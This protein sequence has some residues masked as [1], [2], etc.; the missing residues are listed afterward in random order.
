MPKVKKESRYKD[1]A[2]PK[3][4]MI[5]E[6][7]AIKISNKYAPEYVPGMIKG[8]IKNN[9][10]VMEYIPDAELLY[11]YIQKKKLSSKTLKQM[12]DFLIKIHNNTLKDKDVEKK[13]THPSYWNLKFKVQY[14]ELTNTK[15]Q[16]RKK[17]REF[18]DIMK[19]R[20]FTL[21]H[22]D[23]HFRNALIKKDKTIGVVD[24]EETNFLDS[25]HDV[26]VML[27]D[28]ILFS[29]VNK[30]IKKKHIKYFFNQYIKRSRFRNKQELQRSVIIHT[31][32]IMLS[33]L[34]RIARH[35][36]IPAG[37]KPELKKLLEQAILDE[38]I[39]GTEHFV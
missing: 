9:I 13:V 7:H 37:K 5:N 27:S 26:G 10:M 21:I 18:T 1:Y 32:S 6:Y 20:R 33:R 4:R 3:E 31:S 39:T 12:L 17:R 22:G 35:D 24:F 29:R 25:A 2:M 30:N 36:F 16:V 15:K 23:Y 19:T 28:L 11:N 38:N 34:Y 8:D 14:G